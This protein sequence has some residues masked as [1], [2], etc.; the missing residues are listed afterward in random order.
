MR[1][2]TEAEIHSFR[3]RGN[4]PNQSSLFNSLEGRHEG[5][6]NLPPR[7]PGYSPAIAEFE[8]KGPQGGETGSI[9][10]RDLD[11]RLLCQADFGE[12]RRH[13]CLLLRAR[14]GDGEAANAISAAREEHFAHLQGRMRNPERT[15]SRFVVPCTSRDTH[16][17]QAV[18]HKGSILLKLSQLGYPVPDFVILTSNAFLER[19]THL[20]GHLADALRHLETLTCQT[21]GASDDPLVFALRC[22]TPFYLAGVMPTYLNVGVTESALPGLEKVFGREPAH[23][24]FLNNL[25]NICAALDR[26]RSDALMSTVRPHLSPDEVVRLIE[27][28]SEE[29][30]KT[31]PGLVE[32]PFSQAAFFV[33]QG[34]QYFENNQDLLITLSRGA[35][36]YP[37]VIIQKMVCTVRDK[38]AYAGVLFS[39]HSGTGV[40][41]QLETAQDIF[42]EEIMTGTMATQQ[43]A[44][45]E[46]EA[47]KSTFPAVYHFVPHLA[48]LERRFES[49]V[50]IEFAVDAT[51]THQLF[52]LLQLNE[53]GMVGRAAF[54]SVVDLHKAG[55]ISRKRVTELICPYHVKQIESDAIDSSSLE[56]LDRFCSGVA[57]L[58]R[59]AV[60]ARIFFSAD[61]ALRAKRR[62]EKVCFCKR[63]F[64]PS[65]TVVMREMDAIASLTSAAIHVVTTCQSFGAPALLNLEQ[66]G[67]SL[68]SDGRLVNAAGKEIKEGDW[69]TI[70]SRRQ[71]LYE[72]KARFRPARLMRYMRGEDVPLQDEEKRAFAAMAYAY[73]YYQQLVRGLKL[74]QI[75]TLNEVIRLVNLELRGEAEEA[76]TLVNGWFDSHEQVYVEEVLKGELGDHLNQHTVFDMLSLDRKVRFFK[77]ALEKC[78]RER[79]F[80]YAAGAFMLGRFISSRQPVGFWRAFSEFEIALLIN[81]WILF[82]QYMQI[83][84]DVGERKILRARKALLSD[85]LEDVSLH[86]GIVR[87]LI[88]LK[89]SGVDLH[90]VSASLPEWSNRQTANVVDLL[91]RPYSAFY[92][93]ETEWSVGELKKI[94]QEEDLP[95]PEPDRR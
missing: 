15:E 8:I 73:R 14:A 27:R 77:R 92:D 25:R 7:L 59:A 17:E 43:T 53:S 46:D 83:L 62:G 55:T 85:G 79:I 30:R 61:A 10:I 88:P 74:D 22:A 64:A 42:G 40:G 19:E 71:A 48:E 28:L 50:A 49:P 70:S 13:L 76:R 37:S 44:F 94:C 9:T 84:N 66:D 39:R 33:R 5:Q 23:K 41:M 1:T 6:G 38:D 78:S 86:P 91:L 67:V 26:E 51:K 36:C 93:F 21:L 65:D 89:L 95:L 80:G 72:G 32:D 11:L 82:E 52:A 56:Y 47:I 81:E 18:S 45:E 54:I 90:E 60:S 16:S 75:S 87:C 4:Y 24:M 34:Y 35:P 29:V 63:T 2:L 31:D 20:E 69:I 58:P 3:I 68:E 57:I 12:A